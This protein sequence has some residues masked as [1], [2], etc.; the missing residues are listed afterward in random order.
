VKLALLFA[1]LN[2][3]EDANMEKFAAG[4]IVPWPGSKR[5]LAPQLLKLFPEHTCYCEPFAGA[6]AMLFAKAPS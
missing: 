4:P 5:R 6:A 2:Q 1:S 3:D